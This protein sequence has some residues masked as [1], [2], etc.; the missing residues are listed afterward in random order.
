MSFGVGREAGL[1]GWGEGSGP[2][3]GA[4]EHGSWDGS[5]RVG[6]RS[7]GE[8][9][10]APGRD[11][12]GPGPRPPLGRAGG[13]GR[14][15]VVGQR[16]IRSR[17]AATLGGKTLS[18]HGLWVTNRAAGGDGGVVRDSGSGPERRR[19]RPA[20][21]RASEANG[22]AGEDDGVSLW[23]GGVCGILVKEVSCSA[24][25]PAA[26]YR[27]TNRRLSRVTDSHGGVGAWTKGF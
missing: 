2:E 15:V 18:L 20:G 19:W 5:G 22:G 3:C 16:G 13:G 10:R 11:S 25:A 8:P 26:A 7:K 14:G 1:P 9:G 17:G 27:E 6:P 12:P 21:S 24:P 4:E 23:A